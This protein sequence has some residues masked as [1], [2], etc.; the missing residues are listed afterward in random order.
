MFITK[1]KQACLVSCGILLAFESHALGVSSDPG[2]YKA[3]PTGTNLAVGYYHYLEADKVYNNGNQVADDLDLSIHI[4]MLRYVRF[5]EV[6]GITMNPQI[7]LPMATQTIGQENRVTGIGDILIGGVA[8][9]YQDK[10]KGQYLALGGFLSIPTGS[11]AEKG[12]SVSN[13]R[14]QYNLQGG[15]LHQVTPK[16]SVEGIAQAEFYSDKKYNDLEKNM[17]YQTDLSAIYH[18]GDKTNIAATW[19]YTDGGKEKIEDMTITESEQK[20]MF[21]LSAAKS[22]KPNLQ[23]MLQWRQDVKVE[24]GSKISGLQSRLVYAF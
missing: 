10:D 19:R 24:N 3:L 2:D 22:L 8:W 4:G 15:Y 14:Y 7:V 17:F 20:H 6:A 21:I 13:D 18:L 16:V 11:D 5:V 1:L 9:P 23:L 12:L